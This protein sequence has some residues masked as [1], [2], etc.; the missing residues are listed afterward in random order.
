MTFKPGQLWFDTDGA[1]IN[2]H[3]GGVLF[4]DGVYYWFGEHKIEGKIGNSAQV[5]VGCYSSR[6]LYTWKNEGI[7]LAVT[8]EPGHP[9]EK[10]S[11]IER[12]K[13]VR[14][15]VTGQYAM[16]F[17]LELKGQGYKAAQVALAVADRVTGPY[18][19]V[20]AYRPHGFMSRD[21]TIFVDDDG[22]AWELFASDENA[23]LRIARL[24]PDRLA[25]ADEH[26][27]AFPK[28]YMEAPAVCRHLGRYWFIGS[29]CTGWAPN[30]ARS[31]VADDLRG[32]WTE[33]GNPCVGPGAETT[34]ESQST[35]ILPV[36]DRPGAFIF[37]GDRWRPD[38]AIDGRYVWLP[39]VFRDGRLELHWHDEWDLS[40]FDELT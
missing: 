11:V 6:D 29:D 21:M 22:T 27:S 36:A 33:L 25:H 19:F 30:P 2:A 15:P 34:F 20:A 28:R 24:T 35:F 1:P 8:D 40:V 18:R 10:G 23:T 37:M 5:G 38:N 14:S 31:A 39:L 7:A 3:G 12:P 32:P 13:V 16:W 17:H 9:I 26:H 4:E